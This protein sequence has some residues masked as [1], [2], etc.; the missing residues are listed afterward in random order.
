METRLSGPCPRGPPGHRCRRCLLPRRE[1]GRHVVMPLHASIQEH[2]RKIGLTTWRRS[3]GIRSP[4]PALRQ[5]PEG[6]FW[7]NPMSPTGSS[8]MTSNTFSSRER[9]EV[10]GSP[11]L[12]HGYSRSSR[13]RTRKPGS[14]RSGTL[15]GIDQGAPRTLS[16]GTG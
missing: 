15:R 3:S 2:C 14:A 16:S 9:P 5:I 10:T 11:H 13:R 1:A 7:E 6:R 8:R 12:K 4:M